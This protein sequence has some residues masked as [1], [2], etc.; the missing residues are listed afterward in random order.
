MTSRIVIEKQAQK[1]LSKLAHPAQLRILSFLDNRVAKLENPKDIGERLAGELGD[2][3]KY[4]VGDYR[5][6]A[7][8]QEQEIR[9]TIVRIGHR[10][11][12]YR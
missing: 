3:W 4:R 5:I 10:R 11:N 1:E 2:Y 6:I 7:S 9:I 8:I 12:V